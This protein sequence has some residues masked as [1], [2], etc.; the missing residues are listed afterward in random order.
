MCVPSEVLNP[1]MLSAFQETTGFLSGSS[2]L[3][4][5]P[6]LALAAGEY[7]VWS[8]CWLE[9]RAQS[10]HPCDVPVPAGPRPVSP[11]AQPIERSVPAPLLILSHALYGHLAY[12]TWSAS[13]VNQ[14][15]QEDCG[16]IQTFGA[17]ESSVTPT[18]SLHG[19]LE[20][21][22]EE[23]WPKSRISG[24]ENWAF[25]TYGDLCFAPF[26]DNCSLHWGKDFLSICF[27]WHLISTA[28]SKKV[29]PQERQRVKGELSK[30][31]SSTLN[32]LISWLFYFL[33][34]R[35]WNKE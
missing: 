8:T 17:C 30:N 33:D 15:L 6:V 7:P 26:N 14:S 13:K 32:G 34:I 19:W 3:W 25:L 21:Q 24:Q 31:K 16:Q 18:M 28:L 22:D 1:Y 23:H 11:F 10:L 12:I 9:C 4:E 35:I 27:V 5:A 2:G 20:A 29:K